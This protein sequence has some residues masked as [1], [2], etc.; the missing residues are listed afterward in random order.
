[1]RSLEEEAR[2]LSE[3]LKDIV[4]R[5]DF[6]AFKAIMISNLG[7]GIVSSTVDEVTGKVSEPTDAALRRRMVTLKKL[8]Q[9]RLQ[10]N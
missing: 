3:A 9:L 6:E 4:M 5:E 1:M 2:F 10:H 7:V 8:F